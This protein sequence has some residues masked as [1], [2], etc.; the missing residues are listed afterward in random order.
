MDR[1]FVNPAVLIWARESAGLELDTAARKLGLAGTKKLSAAEK[2]ARLEA[3]EEQPT[4]G[5]LMKMSQQYHRPLLSLYLAEPPRIGERGSDFRTLPEEKRREDAPTV[6]A[7]VRD[8]R[9]RQALVRNVLED[10]DDLPRLKFVGSATMKMPAAEL[11]AV[12]AHRIG[13][14]KAI[15]RKGGVEEAFRYLRSCVEQTGVFVL[16][17]G[18]LGTHHTNINADVFRGFAISDDLAP[19]VVI[20]DQDARVAWSFTL[21]HEL[22]HI[23]L[24]LSGIS[25][26]PIEAKVE[27]Y[28]N[29]VASAV[30]LAADEIQRDVFTDEDQAIAF[31]SEIARRSNVSRALVIYRLFRQ[32]SIS[33]IA[34]RSVTDRF[35]REWRDDRRR[36]KEDAKQKRSAKAGGPNY[37]VVQRF[38]LGHALIDLVRRSISDGALSPTRAGQVLGV[39]ATSVHPLVSE[40]AA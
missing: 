23:W 24:G 20:N 30:L 29:D 3:G 9:G 13:F 25:G 15:F 14:D 8:V 17:L 21:L 27:R 18:N 6:D 19:F 5:V 26:G 28:C 22:A 34:W 37:Y 35:Q 38:H 16:L 7:L 40:K 2:L 39:K 12:I 32:G 33:E 31:A 10:D 11:A 1:E 4:R 36:Q